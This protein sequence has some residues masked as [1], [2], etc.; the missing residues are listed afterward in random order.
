[1]QN[2]FHLIFEDSRLY[3]EYKKLISYT[4]LDE[5][6]ECKNFERTFYNPKMYNDVVCKNLTL[7]RVYIPKR[8]G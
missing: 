3:R 5:T 8:L 4:L 7:F 6:K 1:M 2:P